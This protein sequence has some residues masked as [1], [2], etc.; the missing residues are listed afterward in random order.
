MHHI[1]RLFINEPLQADKKIVATK[2]HQQHLIKVLRIKN[3]ETILLFNGKQGEWQSEIEF[4]KNN[5]FFHIKKQTRQQ[6]YLPEIELW[7]CLLKKPALDTIISKTVELGIKT[8]QPIISQYSQR[9]T[10]N[11]KRS[12]QQIIYATQQCGAMSLANI[13]P[14]IKLSQALSQ[15][16]NNP[17]LFC[18]EAMKDEKQNTLA[19]LKK[20]KPSPLVILI[21]PEGGF[22]ERERQEIMKYKNCF[23]I[24]LG[25]RLLRADT[26]C[27][28]MLSLVQAVLNN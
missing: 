27:I 18:N 16:K 22:A 3:G 19:I 9:Q 13:L 11:I 20:I 25:K 5:V 4:N 21:G 24:T 7:F 17:L 2:I 14:P 1:P 26:A 28:A 23:N 10:I 8:L 15:I 6:D 12:K